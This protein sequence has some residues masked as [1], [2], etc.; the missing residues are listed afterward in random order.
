MSKTPSPASSRPPT[1]RSTD[2]TRPLTLACP[3][4]PFKTTKSFPVG[5]GTQ[6]HV[7]RDWLAPRLAFHVAAGDQIPCVEWLD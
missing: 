5:D 4:D 6:W 1:E 7:R 2:D 3:N